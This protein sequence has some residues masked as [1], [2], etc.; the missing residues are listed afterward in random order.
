MK[1]L[2]N[3]KVIGLF[4]ALCWLAYFASYFTRINYAAVITEVVRDLGITKA[5]AALATTGM[6][7]TYGAGQLI[8]GLLGDRIRPRVLIL[9]GLLAAAICNILMP[10]MPSVTGMVIVWC[11]NGFAHAMLWPPLV[12]IMAENLNDADYRRAC[13]A[14]SV[15]SSV[16]T[17][18]IYF[19]IPLWITISR[20]Q[21][22]FFFCAAV[23]II[24]ALIWWFGTGKIGA[25]TPAVSA[26]P[27]VPAEAQG[28]PAVNH[29]LPLLLIPVMLG[30]VLQGILRD[31]ITTWMPAYISEVFHLDTAISILTAV[32]LPIF[33]IICYHASAAVH[34]KLGNELLSASLFFGIGC[35]SAAILLPFYNGNAILA[36]LLMA[37]ITGCMHGVN[38][39]LI[40]NLPMYFS[41]YGRISTV[42]GMLNSCTYIGSAV[43]TYGFA[44]LSERFGWSFTIGSWIVVAGIGTALCSICI[45]AWKK[46]SARART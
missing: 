11:C 38:L 23:G 10:L 16:A 26:Q 12:R 6:S 44:V 40:G 28:A 43:S 37:L 25:D 30:I 1:K 5:A 21:S 33:S 9:G 20:W 29:H 4:I 35:L 13:V 34:R 18:L 31:G 46:F 41:S 36:A 2:E 3:K 22:M 39:M 7:I 27:K 19:F 24:S 15:A 8:S 32:V 45:G 17:I 42:S 14:V